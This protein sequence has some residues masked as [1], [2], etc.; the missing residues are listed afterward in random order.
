MLTQLISVHEQQAIDLAKGPLCYLPPLYQLQTIDPE[1]PK[2][3]NSGF[4]WV[5]ILL[6]GWI[7][8]QFIPSAASPLRIRVGKLATMGEV[9]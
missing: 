1:P 8:F 9:G 2:L 3:D 4:A 7:L 6:T 5:G